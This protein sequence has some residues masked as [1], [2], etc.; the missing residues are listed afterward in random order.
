MVRIGDEI[1][2]SED[3]PAYVLEDHCGEGTYGIVFDSSTGKEWYAGPDEA[4]SRSVAE[5]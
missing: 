3:G 4:T 5:I 2:L 1:R